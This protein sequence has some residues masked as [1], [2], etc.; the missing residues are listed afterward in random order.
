MTSPARATNTYG[1]VLDRIFNRTQKSLNVWLRV[2]I[3]ERSSSDV[4]RLLSKGADP[5]AFADSADVHKPLANAIRYNAPLDI[6]EALLKSGADPQ[7]PYRFLGR[8][9]YLS[10]AAEISGLH[11]EIVNCLRE[12]E[13]EAEVIN[14]PRGLFRGYVCN[15]LKFGT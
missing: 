7:E 12:A 3:R 1:M 8:E 4:E 6:F 9:F 2:A 14:G 13:R 11:G 10:E 15:P 5:N